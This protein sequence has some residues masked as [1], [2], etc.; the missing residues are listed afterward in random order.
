MET[1][2]GTEAD[3]PEGRMVPVTQGRRRFLVVRIQDGFHAIDDR[4][5]HASGPLHQGKRKDFVI[6]CPFHMSRFDLRTGSLVSRGPAVRDQLTAAVTVRGG[7][8]FLDV[9]SDPTITAK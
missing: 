9:P 7:E 3:F 5:N 4:C 6:E 1:R 2:I 8:V